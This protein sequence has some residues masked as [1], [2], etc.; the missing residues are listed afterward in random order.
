M[1]DSN[2]KISNIDKVQ[3]SLYS[4]TTDGIFVKKRHSLQGG[5]D[6]KTPTS[7]DVKEEQVESSFQI[8][9]NKIRLGAFVFFVLAL[10]FTFSKFF[11]GNNVVSGNNIDVLISGP[12]SIA[13]GD[14]LS[15]DVEVKNNNNIDLKVVD[16]RIE[17]P[18]GTKNATDQTVDLQRYSET[19]GNINIGKS[20]KRIVK[21]VLYGEENTEKIIKVTVEYRV[22]GSNAIFSKEKDFN[23]KIASSPVDIKVTGPSEISANQVADFSIDVG[24]N[25]TNIVKNLILKA[26][27]PFGFTLSSSNPVPSSSDGSVFDIGDLAVGAKRNIRISGIVT[28]QD[29][30]EKTFKFTLGTPSKDDNSIIGT[31]LAVYIFTVSLKKSSIGLDVNIN[32]QNSK[33]VP[34]DVGDENRVGLYWKNNL[35]ESIYDMV[36]KVKFSGQTLDKESVKIDGGFYNSLDNSITFDKSSNSA[37]STIN[38]SDEGNINFSLKTLLP[39]SKSLISFANSSINL[40]FTVLGNKAGVNGSVEQEVLYSDSRILKVSSNLKLMSRGFRTIGPFEN[41]GPFPPRVDNESTY[42]ITWTASNSFNNLTS[43]RVSTFLPPNVTWTGYTSPDS[44][45]VTYDKGTGEVVWN[46]GDMRSGAGTNYSPRTASFQVAIV[47]SISQLGTEL[48]LLNEATISGTDAYSGARIGEV[49]NPVTTNITSDP[50][51]VDD[52][53]KIVQ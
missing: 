39:S 16:L 11:T 36:I 49:K 53:G 45:K 8:P 10:S 17:Y 46:I 22:S 23:V 29:G 15:L 14:E 30:E 47:P 44:E 31:P 28:G 1:M 5:I 19:L 2:E 6:S 20:E 38:P 9:Y 12:M 42:T 3:E 37:F 25:S 33:E 48:N 27:Y 18:V 4:K 43:A 52:V 51:Y 26:D 41:S 32:N 40:G 21:S 7:W 13:G 34:I 24:S 35:T 50:E